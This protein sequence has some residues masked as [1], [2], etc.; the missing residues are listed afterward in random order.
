MDLEKQLKEYYDSLR[1]GLSRSNINSGY[2]FAAWPRLIVKKLLGYTKIRDV[3]KF[4]L[5][6]FELR[7]FSPD[8]KF[9]N[10]LSTLLSNAN[11]WKNSFYD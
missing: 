3:T 9:A 4:E 2:V 6:T 7:T 10:V 8:L 1:V 11:S 5:T